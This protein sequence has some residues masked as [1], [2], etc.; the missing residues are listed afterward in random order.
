[1]EFQITHIDARFSFLVVVE[2]QLV[3]FL[4]LPKEGDRAPL[5]TWVT[6]ATWLHFC[7]GVT[8]QQQQEKALKIFTY[9]HKINIFQLWLIYTHTHTTD[10]GFTCQP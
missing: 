5:V 1:M 3:S 9:G 8:H 2:T 4:L 7:L 10:I 6:T